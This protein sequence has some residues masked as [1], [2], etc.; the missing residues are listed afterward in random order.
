MECVLNIP[1][2]EMHPLLYP[3]ELH[4]YCKQNNIQLQVHI[5]K[6]LCHIH[7]STFE[8]W[9][10]LPHEWGLTPST[11]SYLVFFLQSIT[12]TTHTHT[13]TYTTK[14]KQ[15][16]NKRPT[17]PLAKVS[18]FKTTTH[19]P[20]TSCLTWPPNTTPQKLKSY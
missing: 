2:V 12:H 14:K 20:P 16:T 10:S 11:S 7:T 3:R 15:K 6:P 17:P 9:T 13:H 8:A 19:P 5:Q 18:S 4:E 1:Q